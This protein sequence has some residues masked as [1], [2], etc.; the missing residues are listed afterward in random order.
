M[1]NETGY[2]AIAPE[3]MTGGEWSVCITLDIDNCRHRYVPQQDMT[4]YECAMMTQWFVCGLSVHG[5]AALPNITFLRE[6]DLLRHW[7]PER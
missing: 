6:H 4:A 3:S 2:V 5:V 7:E 1:A